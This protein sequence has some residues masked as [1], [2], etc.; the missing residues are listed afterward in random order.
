MCQ[1]CF[2]CKADFC[3][4]FVAKYCVNTER[5]L[6]THSATWSPSLVFLCSSPSIRI[7]EAIY[8]MHTHLYYSDIL[9]GVAF[10]YIKIR[11]LL[12]RNKQTKN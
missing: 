12:R 1:P 7:A 9:H 8:K 11:Y 3:F 6:D 10:L 5:C 2:I 4:A